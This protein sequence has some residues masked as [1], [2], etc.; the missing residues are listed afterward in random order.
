ME[1]IFFI[2]LLTGVVFSCIDKKS[3]LESV[4]IPTATEIP[5]I[6]NEIDHQYVRVEL[7]EVVSKD[8]KVFGG[9]RKRFRFKGSWY[10]LADYMYNYNSSSK[11]FSIDA[12]NI[13]LKID[14]EKNMS[15]YAKN[16][17]FDKYGVDNVNTNSHDKHIDKMH[18][19]I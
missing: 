15:V 5:V 4:D 18:G 11:S 1:K 6:P 7:D 14:D 8:N 19:S 12:R 2:F 3:L 17:P 16:I 9:F 13:I 10:V